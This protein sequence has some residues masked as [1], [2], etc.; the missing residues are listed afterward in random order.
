MRFSNFNLSVDWE[1]LV[2]WYFTNIRLW[3]WGVMD[4]WFDFIIQIVVSI[5]IFTKLLHIVSHT[6]ISIGFWIR[7]IRYFIQISNLRNQL[8]FLTR[9]LLSLYSNCWFRV[10]IL[11]SQSIDY[12]IIYINNQNQNR[13]HFYLNQN[14]NLFQNCN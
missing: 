10:S 13:I 8:L 9:K 5:S 12:K 3:N 7:I 1:A 4:Y 6:N 11:I 14:K 2:W